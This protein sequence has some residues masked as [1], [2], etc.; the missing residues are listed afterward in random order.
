MSRLAE[1]IE[2][3]QRCSDVAKIVIAPGSTNISYPDSARTRV[4]APVLSDFAETLDHARKQV[5]EYDLISWEAVWLLQAAHRL[6]LHRADHDD[7]KIDR[8]QKLGEFL[9]AAVETDLANARKSLE[10][11]R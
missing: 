1:D 5:R 2:L 8:F 11:M 3:L 6:V 9:L 10:T 4:S 7:V